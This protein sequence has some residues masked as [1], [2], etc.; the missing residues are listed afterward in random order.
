MYKIS[1]PAK[2]SDLSV[3]AV[4]YYGNIGL[5]SR[6]DRSQSGYRLHTD[7]DIAKLA[8]VGRSRR[9]SFSIS[10]C[11][12]LL[13]LYEDERQPTVVVKYITLA[14]IAEI[15]CTL[16]ELQELRDELQLLLE[17]C[18]GDAR[19]NCPIIDRLAAGSE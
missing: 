19:P 12:E 11:R 15:D 18:R 14:K 17:N 10:Q 13:D 1:V 3:K 4:R 7:N 2:K 5:V 6:A 9:Y 8:F 16:S